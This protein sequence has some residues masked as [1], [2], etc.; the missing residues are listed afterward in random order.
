MTK[1]PVPIIKLT[2]PVEGMTCASC[3]A[4]VEKTL[5]KI[6]G[7]EI[8]NVNL[9]TEAVAVTFDPSKTNLDALVKAVDG[10][11][12]KLVLP[13]NPSVIPSEGS[14]VHTLRHSEGYSKLKR[15]FFFSL[16]LA[17]PIM[18]I[19]MISMTSWFMSN[20]PLT[21]DE[22]NKVL[23]ILTTPV[24]IVSGRRFFDPAWRL[25]KQF[26]SDMNT[27]VAVGTGAAFLYSAFVVLFPQWMPSGVNV[28]DVYFDSAAMII[29]LILMG[30]TL[31]AR[32]KYKTSEE[33]QKLMEIQPKTARVI[34]E[35]AEREIPL[36]EVIVGDVVVVR[37]GER[38]PVDGV[39]VQGSSSVDEAMMTGE[40]FP[41]EKHVGDKVVGG[42]I[43]KN[44]SVEF[45]TTAVGANTVIAQIVKLV[46]DAQGSK[47]PIQHLADKIAS[48]FVP[49]VMSVALAAFGVW[50]LAVGIGFASAL[51]NSIAVLVIAC[52]CALG[53]A[54]PTAIMVGTGKGASLG[55]LIKNA[56][57]LERACGVQTIVFDKTGT[58]TV[59]K[60]SVTDIKIFG[61][62]DEQTLLRIIASLENK[63]EHPLSAAIVEEAKN[64]S[65]SLLNVE[66]F[67]S[68]T[69]Y[70]VTGKVNG[71]AV[72]VGSE[73]MMRD[74]SID[75]LSAENIVAEFSEQGKTPVFA[76][77]DGMLAGI[78]AISDTMNPTSHMAVEELKRMGLEVVM[79]TGDN[80]STAK[81]IAAQVEIERV[82][83]KVLPEEKFVKIKALQSE[84]GGKGKIV[85]MVGDGIN[86]APAL[87]QADVSIAMGSGTD[88]AMETADVTLMKSDLN[89][90]VQAI[91][92]SRRTMRTIKQNLF[93]AFIYNIVGIPLAALGLLNPMF[94]A[95]AM[96]FSSVS[97]VTNS[98]RLKS[99][100][101]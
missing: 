59:G 57:S 39:V 41:V 19:N 18:L 69:G 44:G 73:Q 35:N 96:A 34:R 97:V 78:L 1:N 83:S 55:V 92:L 82:F 43:N 33:I 3:V 6:D 9:A 40:G 38:V 49:I 62:K 91:R 94:A 8:A 16:A 85:A 5:K 56:E 65:L 60:P 68:K 27:L 74:L 26:S 52:P 14:S 36:A 45:R 100:K 21:M 75:I 99:A 61:N 64:R 28:N 23:L 54:T 58:I 48:I 17:V 63:S 81:M 95:G 86:D 10:A 53:L 77:I 101:V 67:Q 30:K 87:A 71:T 42:T 24:M 84:G 90:V 70:G 76:V 46:E 15:E 80:P 32:A 51:I 31:E 79:L 7:V 4:R 89:G 50:Y 37:P 72:V 13:R 25:A 22:V 20:I 2:L 98:L 12:Y 66:T 88:V 11:G 93:W 47:A 29:A